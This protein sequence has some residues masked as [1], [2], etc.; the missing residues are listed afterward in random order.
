MLNQQSN[1]DLM[2]QALADPTRRAMVDRLSRGPASV[3][4]L[5]KPFDMSLPAV[6]QHLQALE[7]S[8]LVS[9][10]KV[11]RVRTCQIEP[12]ALSLAEQWIND[13]RTTWV[14]RLDRL[15]E[16]LA[17]TEPETRT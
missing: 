11:G 8:G 9:S 16:F 1:L 12:E 17:E 6:V 3:S 2:F 14:R 13:R 10:Q 7:A 5:A 15:G 4:E